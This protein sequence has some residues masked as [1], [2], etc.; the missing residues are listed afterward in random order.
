VLRCGSHKI[1]LDSH[2][3]VKKLSNPTSYFIKDTYIKDILWEKVLIKN[4]VIKKESTKQYFQ[5][6]LICFYVLLARQN[7]IFPF[8]CF[9]FY[10]L[11]ARNAIFVATLVVL[12]FLINYFYFLTHPCSFMPRHAC[13][14]MILPT[15]SA[16]ELARFSFSFHFLSLLSVRK[17]RRNVSL[18]R[19]NRCSLIH[20]F[21]IAVRQYL[22]MIM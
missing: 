7:A 16:E 14:S 21:L 5:P 10:L 8:L 17:K 11:F 12:L 6:S 2:M 9:L 22:I 4:C 18:R 1:V 20:L 15:Y 19:I 13:C 3:Q